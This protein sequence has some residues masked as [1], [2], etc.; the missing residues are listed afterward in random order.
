[1]QSPSNEFIIPGRQETT[2]LHS[3]DQLDL[4]KSTERAAPLETTRLTREAVTLATIATTMSEQPL[5]TT[6]ERRIGS[7]LTLVEMGRDIVDWRDYKIAGQLNIFEK[8]A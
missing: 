7:E 8:A 6:P 2:P 1:M 5:A 3:G 4:H